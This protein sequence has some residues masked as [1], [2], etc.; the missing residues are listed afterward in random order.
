MI[1]RS[2]TA[3]DFSGL[4]SPPVAWSNRSAHSQLR[5]V[6]AEYAPPCQHSPKGTVSTQPPNRSFGHKEVQKGQK[7]AALAYV[8]KP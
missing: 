7:W 2:G 5:M 8:R 6:G 1:P 4:T 3:E